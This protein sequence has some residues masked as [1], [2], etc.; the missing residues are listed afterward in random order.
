MTTIDYTNGVLIVQIDYARR[1]DIKELPAKRR[2]WDGDSKTWTVDRNLL[3]EL[4][5]LFPDAT[6]TADVQKLSEILILKL[7]SE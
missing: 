3:G 7:L 1:E 2:A 4:L 6:M 5:A